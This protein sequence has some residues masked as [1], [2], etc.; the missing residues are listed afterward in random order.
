MKWVRSKICGITRIEDGLC[1]AHM[2]ADAIGLVFYEKSP[3]YVGLDQARSIVQAMPAFVSI[4]G[5]FVNAQAAQIKQTFD[6]VG[7][8]LIQ[9]HGD[10]TASFCEALALPYIRALRMQPDVDIAQVAKTYV[11]ARGILLDSYVP[12]LPGG[13]GEV[14]NWSLIPSLDKPLI[15]AGGLSSTN[16]AQAVAQVQPWAVDVSG[17]VEQAKG[18]KSA[19]KITDFMQALRA[20]R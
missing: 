5:L 10:E 19:E 14:F 1:A 15:L 20:N 12:G 4:V 9:Y 17:G 2:G 3:R 6:Y 11:N 18:I 8:D 16:I 7:L 13:T